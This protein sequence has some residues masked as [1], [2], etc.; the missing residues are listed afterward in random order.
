[1]AGYERNNA[2]T[3]DIKFFK[4]M[5]PNAVKSL[6]WIVIPRDAETLSHIADRI[7]VVLYVAPQLDYSEA[8][9]RFW[10]TLQAHINAITSA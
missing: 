8:E 4:T 10:E 9:R 2:R 3:T 1:M 7:N 5:R 6:P